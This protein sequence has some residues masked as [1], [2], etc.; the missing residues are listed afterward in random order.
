M[1][2]KVVYHQDHPTRPW[3]VIVDGPVQ[4]TQRRHQPLCGALTFESSTTKSVESRPRGRVCRQCEYVLR[5]N[6]PA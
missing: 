5:A 6:W 4:F 1:N 3:H 2:V